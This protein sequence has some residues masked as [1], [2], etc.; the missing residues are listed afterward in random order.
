[1]SKATTNENTQ[2]TDD[3]MKTVKE[4]QS[5]YVDVQH[6]LGQ[7]SVTRIRVEQQLDALDQREEELSRN[8]IQTQTDEKDFITEVT[9]KYG[10][11]VLDPNTGVYNKTP[12]SE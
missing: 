4:I 8:Y 9:K 7:V 5:R 11:G 2:F 10:D 6:K 12:D 3:E 1:M